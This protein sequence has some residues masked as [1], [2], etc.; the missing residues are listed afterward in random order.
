MWLIYLPVCIGEEEDSLLWCV[1]PKTKAGNVAVAGCFKL[2]CNASDFS[3][4]IE[5]G[6]GSYQREGGIRLLKLDLNLNPASFPYLA[7]LAVGFGATCHPQF[8]N[9]DDGN[10]YSIC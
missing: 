2:Y 10:N 3:W 7:Y 9:G 5:G 4:I 1:I 8:P 6:Q